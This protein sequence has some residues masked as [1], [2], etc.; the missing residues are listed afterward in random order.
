MAAASYWA[1]G[2]QV[3]GDWLGAYWIGYGETPTTSLVSVLD[4]ITQVVSAESTQSALAL[5]ANRTYFLRHLGLDPAGAPDT[6]TIYLSVG[7]VTATLAESSDK[8]PLL[9]GCEITIGPGLSGINYKT[10]SGSPVFSITG[11]AP[12]FG[13][14]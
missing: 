4:A 3:P 10:A 9:N 14:H 12:D 7:T 11:S 8:L 6:S 2:Y 5:D 13:V 1:I